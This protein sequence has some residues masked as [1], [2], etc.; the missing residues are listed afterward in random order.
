M[1]GRD[2]VQEVQDPDLGLAAV[3][4]AEAAVPAAREA[5]EVR[6]RE[7]EDPEAAEQVQARACGEAA[8]ER[9]RAEDPERELELA[10]GREVEE[11][12]PAVGERGQER[13]LEQA[14]PAQ[15]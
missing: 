6:E 14:D 1:A 9:V 8:G 4:W 3:E 7:P 5:A 10:V 15:V 11:V 2:M 12:V 13:A